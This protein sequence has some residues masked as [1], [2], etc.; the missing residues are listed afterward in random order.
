MFCSLEKPQVQHHWSQWGVPLQTR[1]V[2]FLT[3]WALICH[4][5]NVSYWE[6]N[7]VLRLHVSTSQLP[8]ALY[9][10]LIPLYFPFEKMDSSVRPTYFGTFWTHRMNNNNKGCSVIFEVSFIA[11]NSATRVYSDAWR[12][13]WSIQKHKTSSLAATSKTLKKEREEQ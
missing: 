11:C 5:T 9:V 6:Q 1:L 8:G 2:F 13:S 10:Q 3:L 4:P 12:Y 7:H